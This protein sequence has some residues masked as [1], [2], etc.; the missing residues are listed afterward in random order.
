MPKTV[1]MFTRK[2]C[3]LC[4][5]MHDVLDR[6]REK[7]TFELVVIDLDTEATAEKRAAYDWEVPVLEMD[8]R[9]VAKYRI[10]EARL[11]RLVEEG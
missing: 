8:G 7:R 6:A 3:S 10:D 1:T 4:T 2:A 5:K 9:K 11:L